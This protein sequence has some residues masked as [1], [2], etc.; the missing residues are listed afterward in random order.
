MKAAPKLGDE[1][2]FDVESDE[3]GGAAKAA[4]PEGSAPLAWKELEPDPE[5]EA[6]PSQGGVEDSDETDFGSV[7]ADVAAEERAAAAAAASEEAAPSAEP[8]EEELAAAGL[9]NWDVL[10]QELKASA[11]ARERDDESS[12]TDAKPVGSDWFDSETV[13]DAK[14]EGSKPLH[15]SD[16]AGGDAARASGDGA[17]PGDAAK[18]SRDGGTP[19]SEAPRATTERPC[20]SR[21]E[22]A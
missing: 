17:R 9:S 12:E 5:L 13:E 22:S 16:P 15:W 11:E 3:D 7:A 21:P 20:V 19:D 1:G 18:A 14:D 10:E 6:R 8:T 2:F 4:E